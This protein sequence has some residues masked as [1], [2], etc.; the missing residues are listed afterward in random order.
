MYKNYIKTAL[1]NLFKHKGYSLINIVGLAIGMASCL[2]ILLYVQHELSYDNFNEKADQIYR[3]AGSYRYGGRDFEIA[4]SPAAMAGV[5]IKD[6]PE[7]IDAVRFFTFND[8]IVQYKD[9]SFKE[10]RAFHADTSFFNIFSVPLLKGNPE[11]VLASPNK[12]VLS[13]KTAEK[14]FGKEDPIGKTLK[15]DNERDYEVTGIFQEIPDNS[16]FHFDILMSL[17]TLPVSKDMIWVSQNLQTYILLHDKADPKRL[18]AKFP[19][20]IMKYMAPQLEAFLGI[21]VEKM[22]AEGELSAEMYLQPLRKIHLTSDLLG[23]ME[24][25]SDIKYVY[26]FS[27]IALFILI[28]ASINFMN[29]STARSAGRAREV[30]IRKVLGSY[31]KQLVGQFLTES[32]VLSLVS[33]IIAILLVWLALPFFNALSGK[34]LSLSDLGQGLMLLAASLVTLLTGFFAGSYPAFLS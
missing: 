5:M 30:G 9:K 29:L 33:M 20:M 26:I 18:E 31:R 17:S 10:K 4:V 16:H 2:L 6:Y 32:M 24:P 15:I 1:R 25:T 8:F 22:A 23:E 21:S 34:V 19:D 13:P 27:A 28:I 12:I 3:V 14:Y 7:V 11:T